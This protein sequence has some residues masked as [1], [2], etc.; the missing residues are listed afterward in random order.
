M[1]FLA[2]F[3]LRSHRDCE[4]QGTRIRTISRLVAHDEGESGG[5]EPRSLEAAHTNCSQKLLKELCL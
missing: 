4:M 2:P 5:N 1:V 3:Y